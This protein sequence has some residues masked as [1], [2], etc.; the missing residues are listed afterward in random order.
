MYNGSLCRYKVDNLAQ[1][2]LSTGL[3]P[4]GSEARDYSSIGA[5]YAA[6]WAYMNHMP[7]T[8]F[9]GE[10]PSRVTQ[11]LRE[12]NFRI[13]E[14]MQ[15]E[16]GHGQGFVASDF[17]LVNAAL[18]RVV[19]EQLARGPLFCEWGSGFGVVAM[20]ASMLGFEAYGIE[21]QSKLVLAAEELADY[22]GCDVRFAHGSFTASCDEDLIGSVEH[23]LLLTSESNAYEDFDLEPEE[24]DLFFGYPWPG[25]EDIF[26]ALFVRYASIGALL[27]TF[28]GGTGVLVQRKTCSSGPLTVVGWY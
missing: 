1:G 17:T 15:Q 26:D 22:I 11:L 12:A 25:E 24:F 10:A 23:S 20:L 16:R 28:H 9:D 6:A 18:E 5:Q 13:W 3:R 14:H 4:L 21:A 8:D 2:L 7:S 27:L 19:E